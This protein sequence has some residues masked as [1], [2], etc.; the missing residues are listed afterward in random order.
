MTLQNA[1]MVPGHIGQPVAHVCLTAGARSCSSHRREGEK[2]VRLELD[3]TSDPRQQ[4]QL[5]M[6]TRVPWGSLKGWTGLLPAHP[7]SWLGKLPPT[8]QYLQTT[9][10][11]SI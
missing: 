2:H 7:H 10:Q 1:E 11:L 8:P 5:W 6:D 4:S 3:S 9:L